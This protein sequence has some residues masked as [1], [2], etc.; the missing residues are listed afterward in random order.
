MTP[1]SKKSSELTAYTPPYIKEA[2]L[3]YVQQHPDMT[4]SKFIK[5]AVKEKLAAVGAFGE[6]K[7][8]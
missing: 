6:T 5:D 3:N 8:V 4:A 7:R 1:E 2:L